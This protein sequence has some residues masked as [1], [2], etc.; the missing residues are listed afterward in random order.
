MQN[1][2]VLWKED[3]R[4]SLIEDRLPEG[5]NKHVSLSRIPHDLYSDLMSDRL[6]KSLTSPAG[7][8]QAPC[9]R[10]KPPTVAAD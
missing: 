10:G 4:P 2:R 3:G 9:S 5:S 6:S 7:S 1:L 8:C